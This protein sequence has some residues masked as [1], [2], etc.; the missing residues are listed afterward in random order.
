[1]MNL[2]ARETQVAALL[3]EGRSNKWIG[4]ALGL[5]MRTVEVH[6]ASICKKLGVK[7]RVQAAVA[8]DRRYTLKE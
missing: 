4:D 6:A 8:L 1:M 7:N 3:V 5:S 2:T